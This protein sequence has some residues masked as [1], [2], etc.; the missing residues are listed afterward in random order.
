[1]K[2][3][4][5]VY[6]GAVGP[7]SSM[8][9]SMKEQLS[10]LKIYEKKYDYVYITSGKGTQ[11]SS[12]IEEWTGIKFKKVISTFN[13]YEEEVRSKKYDGWATFYD[14]HTCIVENS[15]VDISKVK[16][17][18]IMGSIE[19]IP[20][21]YTR[22]DNG[23]YLLLKNNKQTSMNFVSLGKNIHV[24]FSLARFGK[25]NNV[26]VHTV[27]LDPMENTLDQLGE[28]APNETKTYFG[29]SFAPEILRID[30]LQYHYLENK[31]PFDFKEDKEYDFVFGA[32]FMAGD[33]NDE[34]EKIKI[35]FDSPWRK[36]KSKF[37]I[38]NDKE[39]IDTR[40]NREEYMRYLEKSRFTMVIPSYEK[41]CFSIFRFLE[42]LENDC[43]P[44]ITDNCNTDDFLKS[45]DLPLKYLDEIKIN[46][47][48]I[49]EFVS[50]IS[51]ED[52]VVLLKILKNEFLISKKLLKLNGE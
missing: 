45:F 29:Y 15:G 32:T 10:I 3:I 37:F 16:E 35:L 6:M 25:N 21:K 22:E 33:R 9:Q 30:A 18:L 5:L 20:T 40:V 48:D 27:M 47:K 52:R 19:N 43:L 1:M 42:S 39:G 31:S 17:I 34:Y 11:G 14:K 51:E 38:R 2:N 23:L 12:L 13:L 44:I 36:N 8:L 7:K 4:I 50:S 24:L 28:W 46:P 26:S 41:S 49:F